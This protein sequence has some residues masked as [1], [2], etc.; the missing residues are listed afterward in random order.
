MFQGFGPETIRFFLDI[1]FHNSKAFMDENRERYVSDV[2]APFYAFIEAL[3]PVMLAIDADFET[4]PHKCLSRI[5]RDIRFSN[6][7]SPYRDHLWLAYRQAGRGKDGAP[8]YWF[9]LSPERCGWGVGVWSE[10]RPLMEAMRRRMAARPED[11]L[12]VLPILQKRGF[13]MSGREWKKI[14]VPDT[15]PEAL[16]PWY[17]KRDI[18]ADRSLSSQ[19]ALRPDIV[20]RVGKDFTALAPLYRIFQ[21]CAEEAMNQLEE[22]EETDE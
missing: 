15:L 19:D 11:Y 6:D 16:A 17:K 21:G 8:F 9:E 1:R 2:R 5:N 22:R 3:S 4:R 10:N 13:S 20:D 14:A 7:K 18:Y 12:R